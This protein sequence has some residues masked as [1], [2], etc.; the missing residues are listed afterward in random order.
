MSKL[1]WQAKATSNGNYTTMKTPS[2]YKIDWEDL[3]SNSY[4]SI[5]T[6]NLNRIRVSSKWLKASFTFNY[7]TENEA[8]T[9]LSMINNYPL[10]IKVKSPLFGTD[11]LFECQGYVSKVSVTMQQN[12]ETG[13]TWNSLSFNFVQSKKVASQ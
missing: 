5:T 11:G 2:S 6:G 3:D 4:R 1:L 8:E 12:Q 10:Y 7:L 13:A 9:I